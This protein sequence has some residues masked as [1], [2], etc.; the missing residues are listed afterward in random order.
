MIADIIKQARDLL[1]Y[2]RGEV[3]VNGQIFTENH[4]E[5]LN[6]MQSNLAAILDEVERL[7]EEADKYK[8]YFESCDHKMRKLYSEGRSGEIR[9]VDG[10]DDS[11]NSYALMIT[12]IN[13]DLDGT[14]IEVR[15]P[16]GNELA[17]KALEG[18]G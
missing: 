14:F 1:E 10:V 15:I 9:R 4:L 17:R 8:K 12:K 2:N 6:F 11:G 7:R 13:G 18:E 16:G 5:M 3:T